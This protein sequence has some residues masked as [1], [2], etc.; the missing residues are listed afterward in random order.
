MIWVYLY[1]AKQAIAKDLQEN[2]MI[3][4]IATNGEIRGRIQATSF[5]ITMV[6][7]KKKIGKTLSCTK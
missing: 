7:G 1:F 6:K 4:Q 2:R 3:N 5:R